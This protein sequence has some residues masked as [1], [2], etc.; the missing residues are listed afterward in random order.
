MEKFFGVR[1]TTDEKRLAWR[2]AVLYALVA[3]PWF[4]LS[5]QFLAILAREPEDITW[6]HIFNDWLYVLVTAVLLGWLVRRQ[7]RA[8]RREDELLRAMA[9]GVSV[10]AGGLHRKAA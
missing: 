7:V 1:P 6:L 5:D 3:G 4:F 2:I 10:A 9:Q 8:L